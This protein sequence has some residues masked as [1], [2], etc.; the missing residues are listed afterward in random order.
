MIGISMAV[1]QNIGIIR[2]IIHADKIRKLKADAELLRSDPGGLIPSL[3]RVAKE[4]ITLGK[5]TKI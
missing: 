4:K 1:A 3:S 5:W 2:G